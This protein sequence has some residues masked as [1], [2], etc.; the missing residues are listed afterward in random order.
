[1]YKNKNIDGSLNICGKKIYYLR[2][3]LKPKTSQRALAD[4]LQLMGIDLDKNAIQ[5]IESGKRFVTDIEI[6]AFANVFELTIDELLNEKY[7]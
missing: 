2:K 6:K 3:K 1:M 7:D 4:K 5:K